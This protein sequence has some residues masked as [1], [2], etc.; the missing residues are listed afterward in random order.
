MK[1]FMRDGQQADVQG[2][3]DTGEP[4]ATET[5]MRGSERGGWKRAR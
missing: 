5:G 3:E 2:H 4:R 1:I